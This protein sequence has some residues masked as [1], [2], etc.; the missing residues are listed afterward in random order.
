MRNRNSGNSGGGLSNDVIRDIVDNMNNILN[1]RKGYGSYL[2]DYGIRDLNEFNSRD[3]MIE[4]IID[5]VVRCIE[6]YEPRIRIVKVIKETETDMFKLSFKMECV[7][8]NSEKTLNMVFDT[9]FNSIV[10]ED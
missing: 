7:V 5:E 2:K 8:Q 9:V 4:I 3:G 6:F 1:T 10:V